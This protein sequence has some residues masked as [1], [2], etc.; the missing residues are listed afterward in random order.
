MIGIFPATFRN[1]FVFFYW[2]TFEGLERVVIFVR[3]VFLGKTLVLSGHV[4][5]Q[6]LIAQEGVVEYQITCLKMLL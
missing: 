1:G 3:R 4:T 5:L 2:K 6:K